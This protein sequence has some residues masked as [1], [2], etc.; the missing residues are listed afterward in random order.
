VAHH[1]LRLS[2]MLALFL[3]SKEVFPALSW[4]AVYIGT[5]CTCI[6]ML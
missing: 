3:S 2:A 1:T 6:C 4:R 5:R